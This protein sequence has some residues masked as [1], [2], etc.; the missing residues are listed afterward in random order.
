METKN[1]NK[2]DLM[3][4]SNPVCG[5]KTESC[6][7][8]PFFVCA[9]FNLQTR[10]SKR[11]K[12]VCKT[13]YS[14]AENHQNA[15]VEMLK[16]EQVVFGFRKQENLSDVVTIDEE[17]SEEEEQESAEKVEI[18]DGFEDVLKSVMNKYKFEEQAH[19]ACTHL[20]T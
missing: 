9:Y 17:S 18:E 19:A 7:I 16:Q 3:T 4:C 13:C 12:I 15:L 20:S 14:E 11:Q 1:M 2:E 5:A 8:A 6:S 10:K